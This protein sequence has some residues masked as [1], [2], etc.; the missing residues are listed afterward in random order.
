MAKGA[1]SNGAVDPVRRQ[2]FVGKLQTWF[3]KIWLLLDRQ[4]KEGK[5]DEALF[6]LHLVSLDWEEKTEAARVWNTLRLCLL[7]IA[8]LFTS[9]IQNG[10]D[11]QK[12]YMIESSLSL[13]TSFWVGRTLRLCQ[14]SNP[15]VQ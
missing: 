2:N 5:N 8:T 11:L 1:W 14:T 7:K 6:L 15:I 13:F 9:T 3:Y 12:L 4:W 10:K